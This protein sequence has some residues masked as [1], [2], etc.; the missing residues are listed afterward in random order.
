VFLPLAKTKSKIKMSETQSIEQAPDTEVQNVQGTATQQEAQAQNVENAQAEAQ[1]APEKS[2][3]EILSAHNISLQELNEFKAAKQQKLI[4]ENRPIIEQQEWADTVAFGI[5]EKLISKEDVEAQV[6]LKEKDDLSLV[7]ENFAKNY[8]N[9]D[10]LD[11]EYLDAMIRASFEDEYNMSIDDPSSINPRIAKILKSEADELRNPIIEKI[12]KTKAEFTKRKALSEMSDAH[13]T[14]F[15]EI[16]KTPIEIEVE[17]NG[18]KMNVPIENT[19]TEEELVQ[20]LKSEEGAPMLNYLFELYA[21]DKD[22]SNDLYRS[23]AQNFALAKSQKESIT[24]AVWEK[25]EEHFK[26]VYSVGARNP[27]NSKEQQIKGNTQK[28]T[29]AEYHKR[30]RA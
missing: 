2:I 19:L 27:F 15:Q 3:D 12:S 8:E 14:I 24:K 17:V 30:Q 5:K 20:S 6:K 16:A 4:E 18:E 29:E 22:V 25:A 21:K 10:N 26:Y 23:I 11:G 1:A 7:F 28:M 13:K 9:T